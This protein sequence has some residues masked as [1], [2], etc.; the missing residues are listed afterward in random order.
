M[1][2]FQFIKDFLS[3]QIFNNTVQE[4]LFS[5]FTM[6]GLVLGFSIT[7]QIFIARLKGWLEKAHNS[8][9]DGILIGVL[10]SFGAPA[11]LVTA[12]F[13][14]TLS[15]EL[16][17]TIRSI[18]RY[19]FVIVVTMSG[20]RLLQDTAA[21]AIETA[22]RRAR[23]NDPTADAAIR[24]LRA[25]VGWALWILGAVFILDNLGINVSAVVAGLGIGGIAVAMAS[26]AILGDA[27]SAVSIFIDKPFQIGDSISVGDLT[28]TV[29]HIG[30][31]TT[32]I[33]S[34]HG[35]QL[36][37]SNSDLTSSR[38][39]NFKRMTE[40]RIAFEFGIVYET[41][42]ENVKKIPDTV[43]KILAGLKDVRMDRV[44]FKSFGS[45]ALIYEVVYFVL[46]PDYNVY[47]DRQ[48]SIN[49]ALKETFD[50]EGIEFAYPTQKEIVV[51]GPS[52]K[53]T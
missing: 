51:S 18:I 1:N 26:Q 2:N 17:E 38:I 29:E 31:K 34:V 37:F 39:R 46:S 15:L 21:Y 44:H 16:Q 52:Y 12:L 19:A 22:Y 27:F 50:R 13:I 32:K 48:Q 10:K 43:R 45:F 35:E 28:G 40:R 20:L 6:V 14:S 23:P 42:Q 47:M 36:I 9:I 41:S 49:L 11:F 30:I 7:K 53:T 24:N 3:I 33:R 25:V 4:Y 8:S 5:V